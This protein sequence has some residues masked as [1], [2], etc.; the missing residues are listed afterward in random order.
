MATKVRWGIL[1]TAQIAQAELLPAFMDAS[2]A[3]VVAIASSNNKVNDIASKFG[4]PTIY[5]NY[6]ELLEDP[7]IDAVYIPLPNALHSTWVKKAAEKGKHVFCEKPAALTEKQAEEMIEVCKKNNVM[8]MEAFMYQFHPQHKR[9]KEIIASGEIGDVKI[10]RV[11]LSFFLG[12]ETQNI[13]MN[14]KL[15]GGSLYDVGCYCIHSIRNIL[16]AEPNR[17]FASTQTDPNSQVDM[18]VTGIIELDNGVTAVFDAAMDRTRV[19][20]YEL[21]GTKGSIQVPRAF[22]PQI[23][24]GEGQIVVIGENGDHRVEHT[25]GH[26]Y[27][28]EVEYFSGC[29]LKGEIPEHLMEN[30]IRN[31][32]AIDA[33]IESIDKETLVNVPTRHSKITK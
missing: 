30:T 12:D 20:Q 23:F 16:H 14:Q 22:T 11:S 26:Q 21:I 10:M 8:F 28:L 19:G 24:N 15:G 25:Y 17:V 6:K 3:E 13:R 1:S 5:G 7:N 2:N 29:V 32:S 18:S 4:I 33:C 9:V 27:T 31:M